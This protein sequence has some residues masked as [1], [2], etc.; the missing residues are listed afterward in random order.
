[1]HIH[2]QPDVE[3]ELREMTYA[4]GFA[5]HDSYI[6]DLILRDWVELH[7][8]ELE[9]RARRSI[10]SGEAT[11]LESDWKQQVLARTL[12]RLAQA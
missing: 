10:A 8:E 2:I 3:A 1:M 7:R 4:R 9:E 6:N 5:D 12:Q 11:L